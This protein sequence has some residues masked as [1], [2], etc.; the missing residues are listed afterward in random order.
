VVVAA[1]PRG[2]SGRGEVFAKAI[3]ADWGNKDAQDVLAAV[4][5]V[6][7]RGIA[8]PV[9]LGIGGWS[10][11]GMLTNYTIAQDTR[12]K[13][14]VSGASISNIL[15]GYGTDEYTRDYEAELGTP[16]VNFDTWFRIS[17]PFFHADRIVTPTLFMCG[18]KDF[19]VPLLN[20]EQM[21]QALR[22][23]GRDTQLIIYPG[24]YHE[25]KKPSFLSDR[26]ERS[27]AWYDKYLMA[28]ALE[29]HP[30][31]SAIN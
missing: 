3:Y 28:P 19:N 6:V 27:L 24:Q 31:T 8:D 26:L 15:A 30:S 18:D 16:W 21:Y 7:S 9:R 4:D 22:S 14:A 20:S 12:F 23:L 1:N 11:G 25:I 2:S 29:Q 17:F 10:Y 5:Y 13:A